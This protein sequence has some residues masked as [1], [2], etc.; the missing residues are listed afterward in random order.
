MKI[1]MVEGPAVLETNG[2]GPIERGKARTM[3]DGYATDLIVQG[4]VQ[5]ADEESRQLYELLRAERLTAADP[6]SPFPCDKC[7]QE[8]AAKLFR[9]NQD[10]CPHCHPPVKEEVSNV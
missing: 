9:A 8:F 6:E 10:N 3:D 2:H 1:V 4:N 5:P 7:R